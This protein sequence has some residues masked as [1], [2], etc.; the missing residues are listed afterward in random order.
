MFIMGFM[1][2]VV[3]PKFYVFRFLEMLVFRICG[4][5][6]NLHELCLYHNLDL[7][8]RFLIVY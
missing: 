5:R 4:V 7:D 6:Q 2:F 8:D 3:M 1:G